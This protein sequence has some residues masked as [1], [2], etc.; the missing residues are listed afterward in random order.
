MVD[1][2]IKKAR[3]TALIVGT[4]LSLTFIAFVY[5]FVKQGEASGKLK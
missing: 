3:R 2:T 5:G 4:S 1:A